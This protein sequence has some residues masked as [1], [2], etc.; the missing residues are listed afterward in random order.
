[1]D[2]GIY[3]T[4]KFEKES[5]IIN[6]GLRMD[7]FRPGPPTTSREWQEQWDRI[8]GPELRP[9]WPTIHYQVDPRLGVSFPIST[10]TNIFFSYGH[11]NNVPG[12]SNYLRDPYSG[13]FT[14]NP[15]LKFPT[16]V[17]YEFGFTNEFLPNWAIDIKNYTKE[18]SGLVGTTT[19]DSDYGFEIYLSDNKGYSRARGLEFE[20]R[21]Q[22]QRTGLIWGN[23]I[24]TLQ[25]ASGYSSSIF[26]DYRR[27]LNN[28]PNPIRERR[29]NWDVRHQIIFRGNIGLPDGRT[30]DLFGITLPDDWQISIL[31]RLQS[32]QPYTPGTNDPIEAQTL[33]NS[34]T[35]PPTYST[36]V[37]FEKTFDLGKTAEIT[38]G[39]DVDNIFNQYNVHINRAFN[40]WTGEPFTY[41]QKIQDTKQYFDYYDMLQKLNPN[42]FGQGRHIELVLE[43]NW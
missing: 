1:M 2:G 17:K 37:K 27:S 34:R 10:R 3:I 26:A 39:L 38:V 31:S 36:D 28:I 7:W 21:K 13:G 22:R 8:T 19:L 6:A 5:L 29:L 4:D 16:T 18:S 40:N 11:F 35:G 30:R 12:L 41:G 33:H 25:W 9:D 15:H 24:Y 20:L 23:A 43:T 14:G 42:R 32:G